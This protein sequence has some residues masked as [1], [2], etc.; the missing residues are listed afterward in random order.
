MK[1]FKINISLFVLIAL[2]FFCHKF[3]LMLNYF[4]ALAL[5]E[6]AHMLVASKR[7]YKIKFVNLSMF[8]LAVQLDEDI[9]NHDA[10]AINIAGP[11]CNL[12]LSV[13]C[14]AGFAVWPQLSSIFGVFCNCNLV[15]AFF[16]LLPI[17]PLDGGKIFKSIFKSNKTYKIADLIVRCVLSVTFAVLFICSIK[18]G[19]NLFYLLFALFFIFS[20]P[21]LKPNLSLF[22]A[23]NKSTKYQKVA[24]LKVG[25]NINL[26]DMLKKINTH[27][28]TIFYCANTATKFIDEDVVVGFAL[29]YPLNTPINKIA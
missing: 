22:K 18:H 2:C 28:F 5:H 11:F 6:L 29:K 21:N 13:L 19:V 10:F 14:L 25:E 23:K 26:F 1:K 16:N 9:D 15:L 12:I 24:L 3:L 8:G 4:F 27:Q 20:K 7:G 17:Y